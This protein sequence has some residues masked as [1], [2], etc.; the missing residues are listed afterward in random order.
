MYFQHLLLLGHPDIR[1]TQKYM[2]ETEIS[3]AAV[4]DLFQMLSNDAAGSTNSAF[5][6]SQ[7]RIMPGLVDSLNI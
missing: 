3:R 7:T 2:A 4:E 1:T 6:L 5:S